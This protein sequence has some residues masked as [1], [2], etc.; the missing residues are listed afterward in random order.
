MQESQDE[1]LPSELLANMANSPKIKRFGLRLVLRLVFSVIVG[2]LIGDS[3]FGAGLSPFGLR[4]SRTRD[5]I[6]F[7]AQ[8]VRDYQK[9]KGHLPQ[10]LSDIEG[11]YRVS[12]LDGWGRPLQFVPHGKTF[13]LISLGQDGVAGGTGGDADISLS[14]PH[15]PNSELTILEIVREPAAQQPLR[16]GF[17]GGLI[18]TIL[19]FLILRLPEENTRGSWVRFGVYFFILSFLSLQFA[20]LI[21]AIHIYPEH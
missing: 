18:A 15:P 13:D 20:M 17:K 19:A 12:Q 1:P 6:S 11:L 3:I 10:A 2:L 9:S 4:P 16:V 14:N 7:V 21:T 8:Y 5:A